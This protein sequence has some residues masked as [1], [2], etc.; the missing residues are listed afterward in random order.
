MLIISYFYQRHMLSGPI[1]YHLYFFWL[2]SLAGSRLAFKLCVCFW[3]FLQRR[4]LEL[5]D[6]MSCA[7]LQIHLQYWAVCRWFCWAVTKSSLKHHINCAVCMGANTL[8]IKPS[9]TKHFWVLTRQSHDINGI[10]ITFLT[11]CFSDRALQ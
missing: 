3:H 11:S 1:S 7:F 8:W 10:F 2:F 5:N 6:K 9:I 4:K